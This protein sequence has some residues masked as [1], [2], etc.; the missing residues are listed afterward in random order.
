MHRLNQRFKTEIAY[1]LVTEL[2][3]YYRLLLRVLHVMTFSYAV[4]VTICIRIL[5]VLSVH[6]RKSVKYIII[7]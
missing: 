4:K 2:F 7:D 1:A 3:T 6:R 5:N